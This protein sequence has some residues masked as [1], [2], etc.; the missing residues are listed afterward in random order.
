MRRSSFRRSGLSRLAGVVN[1]T[2]HDLGLDHKIKEQQ[3]A[4]NWASVVG[5]QIAAASRA[6]AIREGVLFV[7]C[8]SSAWSN[9]LSLHKAE[10]I[11]R[12]NK[13]VGK[14][15]V[16]DIRFTTRGYRKAVGEAPKEVSR[17][18]TKDLEAIP[19]TDDDIAQVHQIASSSPSDELAAKIEK[20]IM[21][22]KRLARLKEQQ[23]DNK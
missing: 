3:A 15:V 14:A 7:C 6:D 20:A 22:S 4:D 21:T 16:K 17:L 19:L 1:S 10:I 18:D 2:L 11:G 13:S 12:L 9:E 8:K 23:E 5:A